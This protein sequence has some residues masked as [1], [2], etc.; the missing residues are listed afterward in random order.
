[1]IVRGKKGE[2]LVGKPRRLEV[3]RDLLRQQRAAACRQGRVGLNQFLVQGTK[4]DLIGAQRRHRRFLREGGALHR[5]RK[6]ER[7]EYFPVRHTFSA[8]KPKRNPNLR[9]SRLIVAQPSMPASFADS[10]HS[11]ASAPSS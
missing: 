6:T 10:S 1:M 8:S 9:E 5:Y 2:F 11:P 4:A 7:A 3:H